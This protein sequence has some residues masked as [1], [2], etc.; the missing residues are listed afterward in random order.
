MTNLLTTHAQW[1]GAA[2]GTLCSSAQAQRK[3]HNDVKPAQNI[4]T[5]KQ[6]EIG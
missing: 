1:Q 3:F 2:A 5:I 4:L 6:N